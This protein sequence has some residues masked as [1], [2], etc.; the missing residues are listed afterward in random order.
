MMIMVVEDNEALNSLYSRA[1]KANG[2]HTTSVTT[3]AQAIEVLSTTIPE[4]II[5]DLQL[6]DGSGLSL[7]DYLREREVA[8]H[9]RIIAVSGSERYRKAE[10]INGVHYLLR[11]PVTIISLVD[12]VRYLLPQRPEPYIRKRA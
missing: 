1:L 2:F 7:I 10:D 12:T 3:L 4:A 11:K 8:K 6:S 9:T 5:L